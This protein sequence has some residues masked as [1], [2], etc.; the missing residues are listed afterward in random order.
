MGKLT[1]IDRSQ[2]VIEFD[3]DGTIRTAN[4]NFL[5]AMGYQLSEIVGQHHRMFV[6]PAEAA[7]PS[8][9]QFWQDLRAGKFASSQ[10]KRIAKG[11]REVWIQASYNPI[12][13]AEGKPTGVVKFATDITEQ[14]RMAADA[15][16]K[17]DAISRS[18]A[19]I[20]FDLAGEIQTANDN[21]L[22]AMG[23]RLDEIRGRHHRMFVEH[24]YA[25]SQAYKD[26]WAALARGEFQ[27]SEYKRL[28]K[29]GQRDLD[30]GDLQSDFRRGRKA[31]QSRQIRNRHYRSQG[32][33]KR[34]QHSSSAT[35]QGRS[36]RIDRHRVSGRPRILASGVQSILDAVP[37]AGDPDSCCDQ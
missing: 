3:L 32:R 25:D 11:A 7:S 30:P 12:L 19:V 36:A 4:Q 21:F 37:R 15:A 8:Y 24:D 29:G 1:A 20:E 28:G 17:I 23:Y 22:S 31:C 5:S 18:Q 35:R 34:P 10:Y 26:F 9:A 13:D 14:K 6:D 33:H 16:G 27:S 2:A